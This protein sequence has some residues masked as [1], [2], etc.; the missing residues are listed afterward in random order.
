MVSIIRVG[1]S[2]AIG[3]NDKSHGMQTANGENHQQSNNNQHHSAHKLIDVLVNHVKWH[4]VALYSSNM[5]LPPSGPAAI[6]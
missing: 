6:F 2:I 3:G 5:D 4:S 1:I